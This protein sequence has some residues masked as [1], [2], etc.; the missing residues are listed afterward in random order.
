MVHKQYTIEVINLML[1]TSC[2][3][4]VHL[5]FTYLVFVVAISHTYTL[6]PLYVGKLLRKRQ[7]T[8]L[9]NGN[10][11]RGGNNFRISEADR[12]WICS[13]TGNIYNDNSS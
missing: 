11:V 6:G 13:R 4:P 1:D 12:R 7:A 2:Q 8:F 3:K 10:I 9:E 5:L